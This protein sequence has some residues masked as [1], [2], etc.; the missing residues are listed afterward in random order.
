MNHGTSLEALIMKDEGAGLLRL[1]VLGLGVHINCCRVNL[2]VA[3]S[4]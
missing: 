1:V 2:L 4:Y 3:I